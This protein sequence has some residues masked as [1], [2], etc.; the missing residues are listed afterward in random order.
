MSKNND[1]VIIELDRPRELRYGHKAIKMLASMG[2]DMTTA[3][4]SA[5]GVEEIEK[6]IYCGL[7]SDARRN[8]ENLKLDDMEDLLDQAP[9]YQHIIE[10]MQQAF[11]AAFGEQEG[12]VLNPAK[13]RKNGTGN[14]V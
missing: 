14:K 4:D 13:G 5:F 6:I 3:D 7:L 10:K 8:G 1:V 9:S 2:V 11:A 12:N